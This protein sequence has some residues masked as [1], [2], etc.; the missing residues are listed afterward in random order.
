MEDNLNICQLEDNLTFLTNGRLHK[1]VEIEDRLM[2]SLFIRKNTSIGGGRGQREREKCNSF[3]SEKRA[4]YCGC[5]GLSLPA[6][7]EGWLGWGK[8]TGW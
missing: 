7:W 4:Q 6:S 3:R 5:E 2:F 1:F 8:V